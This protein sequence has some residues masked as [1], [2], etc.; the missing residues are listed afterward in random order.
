MV[1]LHLDDEAAALLLEQ[2]RDRTGPMPL[3]EAEDPLVLGLREVVG[4]H[5]EIPGYV[6]TNS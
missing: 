2:G 5:R 6:R 3:S 1:G 4:I